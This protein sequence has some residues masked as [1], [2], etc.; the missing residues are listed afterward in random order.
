M[1]ILSH[2]SDESPASGVQG[3]RGTKSRTCHD[4]LAMQVVNA[5]EGSSSVLGGS[6]SCG[7]IVPLNRRDLR[8][9]ETPE[10]SCGAVA[11][12]DVNHCYMRARF[13]IL[14]FYMGL[15]HQGSRHL[16]PQQKRCNIGMSP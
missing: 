7:E 6:G 14:R 16:M 11:D 4:I 9:E 13:A 10:L 5:E 12:Q 2:G 3:R 15:L 8:A 1:A